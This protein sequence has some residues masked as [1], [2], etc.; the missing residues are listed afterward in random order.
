MNQNRDFFKTESVDE[1][2]EQFSS[3]QSGE[4]AHLEPRRVRDFPAN[5]NEQGASARLVKE[6]QI[7]HQADYEQNRAFLERARRRI[8]AHQFAKYDINQ[9]RSPMDPLL[10]YVFLKKG[11]VRCNLPIQQSRLRAESCP[12]DSVCWLQSWWQGC[13]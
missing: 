3:H 9:V 7:F 6:L 2:V 11:L 12:A 4:P 13:W 10:C 8:A 1:Q 5:E